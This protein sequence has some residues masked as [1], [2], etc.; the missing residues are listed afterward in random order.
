MCKYKIEGTRPY[1]RDISVVF[2]YEI[3]FLP[4]KSIRKKL[5][6]EWRGAMAISNIKATFPYDIKKVWDIVTY[7][8]IVY[9]GG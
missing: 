8:I 3:L 6:F 9:R 1:Y 7:L 2:I 5:E 4:D